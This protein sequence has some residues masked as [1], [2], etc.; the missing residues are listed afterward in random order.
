MA[1]GMRDL[2]T[3]WERDLLDSLLYGLPD[4]P[5]EEE[6]EESGEVDCP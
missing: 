3:R 1:Y 6:E 4:P 5:P 2:L